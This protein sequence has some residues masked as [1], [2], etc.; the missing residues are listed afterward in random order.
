MRD[1]TFARPKSWTAVFVFR[2]CAHC[3][4]LN[5]ITNGYLVCC[6]CSTDL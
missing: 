1:R 6:S 2:T 4:Q 5:V 3:H